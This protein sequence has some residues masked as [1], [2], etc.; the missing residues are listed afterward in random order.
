MCALPVTCND[1]LRD[2]FC[3]FAL[4]CG[5]MACGALKPVYK[6][7]GEVMS[8]DIRKMWFTYRYKMAVGVVMACAGLAVGALSEQW[9]PVRTMAP[10][11]VAA[12]LAGTKPAQATPSQA[13]ASPASASP[14]TASPAE[15]EQA[16]RPDVLN[17]AE[18]YPEDGEQ[19]GPGA[20]SYAEQI[21]EELSSRESQWNSEIYD[22]YNQTPSSVA[23]KLGVPADQ[24]LGT[25]NPSAQGQNPV[26]P[27]TWIVP[28]FS[29]IQVTYLNGDGTASEWRSNIKDIL[30]MTN[31]YQYYEPDSGL[32]ELEAYALEL[33][34]GSH[35]YT[36]QISPVYYCDGCLTDGG[37]EAEAAQTAETNSAGETAG[38]NSVSE[39]AET[40]S[41][42]GTNGAAATT[43]GNGEAA[44]DPSDEAQQPSEGSYPEAS[45]ANRESGGDAAGTAESGEESQS[46]DVPAQERVIV[47]GVNGGPGV[48]SL[49]EDT[50]TAAAETAVSASACPGHVDLQIQ[51]QV[52]GL[53]E[54]KGLFA[55]DAAGNNP[56][57]LRE[58]GW[59]GWNA[60]TRGY[61]NTLVG[62]DWYERYG[63]AVEG[64]VVRNPLTSL[65]IDLYMKMVPDGVSAERRNVVRYALASVGRIPYYWGGKPGNPGYMGN[66]FGVVVSPDADGRFLKGLDCS[67]WINWVYWSATGKRL[68]GES[69]STLVSCG[70]AV[71]KDELL[72]GDICIRPGENAHVVMFLGWNAE[73]Q[74]ICLQETSG[75]I[76]NVEVGICTPEWAH[77]RRLID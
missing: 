4:Q 34:S 17:L 52:A 6:R 33:W 26:D 46:P 30:A 11:P 25:Y 1:L 41:A 55:R 3:F 29:G 27:A 72:P 7:H 20:V 28:E 69:T 42:G 19:G 63:I 53:T 2:L 18:L 47:E 32:G 74:M 9:T 45:A 48:T 39:T 44:A 77:Y 36:C 58:G 5:I 35:G 75:N 10:A 64:V 22:L 31:V 71:G 68:G 37:G 24:L 50:T 16:A 59:P 43:G 8:I 12:L 13:V 61:V 40:N 70:T 21:Y 76:N 57:N 73:G 67:G 15:T 38:T 56:A 14:D 60:E 51:L 65:E 54:E 49:P 62:E 23:A 66:R